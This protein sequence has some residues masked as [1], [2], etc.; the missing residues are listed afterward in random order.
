MPPFLHEYFFMLVYKRVED[1]VHIDFHEV[2]EILIVAACYRVE[3]LVRESHGV[4]EG[5]QRT[6]GKLHEWV[7]QGEA[8]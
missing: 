4:E 8:F 3:C 1:R 2:A 5:L 7:F 6:L